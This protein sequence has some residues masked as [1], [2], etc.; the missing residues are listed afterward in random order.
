MRS[1]FKTGIVGILCILF[2]VGVLFGNVDVSAAS[3]QSSGQS[4]QKVI[5]LYDNAVNKYLNKAE[6]LK[7]LGKIDSEYKNI[8]AMV[9]SATADEIAELKSNPH[10]LAVEEDVVV[11]IEAQTADWGIEATDAEAAWDLGY[12]GQGVKIAVIDTGIAA[13]SDLEIAGGVSYVTYTKS[14]SDDNGHGTH[15][16]GIISAEDNDF[17]TVGIAPDASIYAVK[18]LDEYG[19]GD[20]SNVIQG[21]DWAITNDMDIINMSLGTYQDIESFEVILNQAYKAGILIVAAAGNDGS[22]SGSGDTVDYPARYDS[23]IA[24]AATDSSNNRAEFSSTGPA[25]EVAAP[26]VYI[27]STYLDNQYATMS[28]TSMATPYVSGDIALLMEA[29]PSLTPVQIRQLLQEKVIDLSVLGRDSLYGYGLIQAYVSTIPTVSV[30]YNSQGGSFVKPAL[31]E[32]NSTVSIPSDPTRKGYT[33]HGWYKEASCSTPWNFSTDIVSGNTTLYAK[34]IINKYTV[35][36]NS[37]GGSAVSSVTQNFGTKLTAPASP[38]KSGYLF[39]GWYKEAACINVWS[40]ASNTLQDNMTLYAKW[41]KP[42]KV[43]D[44][45]ASSAGYNSI[46]VSWS[47]VT[48][49]TGYRI[50]RATSYSGTYQYVKSTTSTS[51]TN[52]SLTTNKKYYYKVR[53]YT[54][55]GSETLYGSYSSIVSAKPIPATPSVTVKSSSYNS[56]KISWGKVS[57]ASGYKIYRATSKS[58]TYKYIKTTTST[59][60]TNSY[61]ATGKTYYYKVRAYRNVGSSKVYSNYS[62]IKSAK[63]VPSKPASY[64]VAR[65]SST[66]IKISYSKVS[67]ASGYRIYRATSYNGTYSLV[68]TTT[69]TSW[70]NSGRTTG[71]TYY[72][73][74]RAYRWVN[75]SRVYGPYTAIKYTHT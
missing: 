38:T 75:N 70:V 71:K 62:S 34:W 24:V 3:T 30:V 20:L 4:E 23:V 61:L 57:G 46:K 52:S 74:V 26:G 7:L 45:K 53:A 58:G 14:Y 69:S 43:L 33:F 40:F 63:P 25:V 66:S 9:V 13:H 68:K 29:N 15:V 56:I 39:G 42:T 6:V 5:V 22:S 2:M 8:P 47:K 11:S 37:Q 48:D 36:Y 59:S 51:W 64:S 54:T 31:V 10:V 49:A 72:Y 65:Y 44:V 21:I 73:K 17:G 18:V 27:K 50:Y 19:N 55:V 32:Q 60:Y 28:G 41:M 12:T 1:K 67:G 16:A 35:T